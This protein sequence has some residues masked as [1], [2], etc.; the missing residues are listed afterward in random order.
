MSDIL[1]A[2]IVQS[3]IAAVMLLFTV[4]IFTR[5]LKPFKKIGQV[6]EGISI[7]DTEKT[8]AAFNSLTQLGEAAGNFS[9]I[10]NDEELLE[11]F[12]LK[13]SRKIRQIGIM[14]ALG[15]KSGDKAHNKIKMERAETL[16]DEG[17]VKATKEIHPA[18][19]AVLKISGLDEVLAD[20]PE[21][22]PFLLQAAGDKGLLDN[23]ASF[24]PN[25]GN[26]G[27]LGSLALPGGLSEGEGF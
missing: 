7:Q 3:V 21:L 11:D 4:F 13:I 26:L 14:T 8:T 9:E 22:L 27:D 2:A 17:M 10:M 12:V 18:L 20:E 16:I 5:E 15:I 6:I 23:L 24:L 25:L 1:I 19:S